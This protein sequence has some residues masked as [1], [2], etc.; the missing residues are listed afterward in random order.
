LQQASKSCA[1]FAA[2]IAAGA[3]WSS[4]LAS[5]GARK[6]CSPQE[7]KKDGSKTTKKTK[8]EMQ[9]REQGLNKAKTKEPHP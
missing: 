6:G 8:Y 4:C 9:K 2:G 7:G 3:F 1:A 5:G